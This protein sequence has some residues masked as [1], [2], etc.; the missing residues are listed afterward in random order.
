MAKRKLQVLDQKKTPAADPTV[1]ESEDESSS[2]EAESGELDEKSAT[3]EI[4]KP[5]ASQPSNGDQ[6]GKKKKRK[7]KRVRNR[8]RRQQGQDVPKPNKKMKTGTGKNKQ[9]RSPPADRRKV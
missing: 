7:D 5:A 8:K 3:T 9:D 1:D 2:D 6:N 4:P